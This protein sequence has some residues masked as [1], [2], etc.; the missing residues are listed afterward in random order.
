[1]SASHRMEC[2]GVVGGVGV[3]VGLAFADLP[4]VRDHLAQDAGV[5][6]VTC[7]ATH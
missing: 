4:R 2:F 5:L 1:M 3:P 7:I 6:R